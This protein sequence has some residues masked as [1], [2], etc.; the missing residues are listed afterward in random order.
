MIK[1]SYGE[2]HD[3]SDVGLGYGYASLQLDTEN[4]KIILDD[5]PVN[6][7]ELTVEQAIEFVQDGSDEFFEDDSDKIIEAILNFETEY[8]K[9]A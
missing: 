2:F 9:S 6:H 8:L 1:F 4:K 5:F 3:E 7:T